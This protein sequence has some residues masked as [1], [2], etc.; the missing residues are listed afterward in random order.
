MNIGFIYCIYHQ[1]CSM[2]LDQQTV[3]EFNQ[4]MFTGGFECFFALVELLQML[5]CRER[6]QHQCG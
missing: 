1:T 6:K 2:R 5:S 4:L 3:V